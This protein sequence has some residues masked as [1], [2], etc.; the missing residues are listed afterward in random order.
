MKNQNGMPVDTYKLNRRCLYCNEPI[1]D[2]VH[3]L[4]KHCFREVMNDGSVLCCKDDRHIEINSKMNQPYK[5]II[6]HHKKMQNAI[7]RLLEV[8]GPLVDLV[9]LNNYGIMLNRPLEICKIHNVYVYFFV[10]YKIKQIVSNCYKIE[11][12]DRIF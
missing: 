1:A 5:A 11:T 7:R 8:K 3:K 10:N 12:N 4:R 6:K 2:Q 9:D